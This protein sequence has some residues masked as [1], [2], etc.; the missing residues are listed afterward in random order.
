MGAGKAMDVEVLM[1]YVER[2][3]PYLNTVET[4]HH[5][6]EAIAFTRGLA[7]EVEVAARVPSNSLQVTNTLAYLSKTFDVLLSEACS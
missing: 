2:L 5:T 1:L 3:S 4:I 7:A 6:P